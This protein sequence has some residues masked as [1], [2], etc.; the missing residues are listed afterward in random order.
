MKQI[1]RKTLGL[2]RGSIAIKQLKR[3]DIAQK[4]QI[5]KSYL[6]M[7]LSGN[8]PMSDRI[9]DQL[10]EILY[11]REEEKDLVLLSVGIS[12]PTETL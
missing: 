12:A 11:I 6:T 1:D 8:L 10:F 4:L 3:Q 2:L 7:M 5:S 9:R